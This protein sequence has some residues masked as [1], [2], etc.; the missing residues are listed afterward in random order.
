MG[1]ITQ[2][3]SP[4]GLIA[5]APGL[6]ELRQGL[7]TGEIFR[8]MCVKCDEFHNLHLDLG[9]IKGIIPR[10]EA[11]LGILEGK[12]REIAILSRVG[13]PVCF[14]VMHIDHSGTIIC[15]RRRAQLEARSYF[16]SALRPGDIIPAQIQ[17]VADFGIFCD[18][19]CG[20]TALMRIDRCCISRLQSLKEHYQPGQLIRAA[21]LSIDD[22]EGQITLTGRELLGTWEENA[23]KYRQGQTVTGTVRSIMPYGIFVELTPNLS[24]LAEPMPDLNPGDPVSVYIRAILPQKHKLKL[25]ILEKLPTMP[26]PDQTEYFITSGHIDKWEYYPGSQAVTYF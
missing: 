24:G 7:N 4:E 3:F 17:T 2:P 26:L 6:E 10:E 18:I 15:S 5:A 12:L 8:A 11:A 23:E 25:N 22:L 19:G 1:L 14:Q 13:K 21:I 20:Y 9:S 16:L